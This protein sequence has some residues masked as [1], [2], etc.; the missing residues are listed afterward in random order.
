MYAVFAVSLVE[1]INNDNTTHEAAQTAHRNTNIQ[2][3]KTTNL[4]NLVMWL[5]I[6]VY[7]RSYATPYYVLFYRRSR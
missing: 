3:K 2:V 4:K 1:F 6:S 5:L 7:W